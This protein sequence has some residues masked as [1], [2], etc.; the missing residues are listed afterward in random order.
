MWE[1]GSELTQFDSKLDSSLQSCLY[2]T[3][4]VNV[5]LHAS[6]QESLWSHHYI[7]PVPIFSIAHYCQAT[8]YVT[9]F[10]IH[11][12]ILEIREKYKGKSVIQPSRN[13]YA[14]DFHIFFFNFFLLLTKMRPA[15]TLCF[16]FSSP[17]MLYML[18]LF[19]HLQFL[20]TPFL[21]VV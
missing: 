8:F 10:D 9:F 6:G 17:N 12:L 13:N 2:C 18:S 14:Y 21:M 16:L 4:R 15:Y 20:Y 19:E 7:R 1:P 11:L 5:S 3:W